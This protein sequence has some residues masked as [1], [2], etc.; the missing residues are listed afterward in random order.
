MT[1]ATSSECGG[2][3]KQTSYYFLHPHFFSDNQQVFEG[4]F[5][6]FK[7]LFIYICKKCVSSP[8]M[9]KYLKDGASFWKETEE[10]AFCLSLWCY[11]RDQAKAW[12]SSPAPHCANLAPGRLMG[13]LQ[14]T[15]SRSK[16][17][18]GIGREGE[19]YL[20]LVACAAA[21]LLSLSPQHRILMT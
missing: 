13:W 15:N 1:H 18:H 8:T 14:R 6:S 3:S 7:Y 10:N 11:I 21:R 9:N 19:R 20:F 5:T 16:R 17:T 2:S 4:L 12:L